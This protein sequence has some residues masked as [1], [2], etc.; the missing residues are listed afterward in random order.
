MEMKKID[1]ENDKLYIGVIGL[2]TFK[3]LENLQMK[4]FKFCCCL[5]I[6]TWNLYFM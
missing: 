4:I 2:L 1:I 3:V 5:K 6:P